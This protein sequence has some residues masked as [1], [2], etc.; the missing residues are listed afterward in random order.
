MDS[1]RKTLQNATAVA[2]LPCSANYY[3]QVLG[4]MIAHIIAPVVVAFLGVWFYVKEESKR[5]TVETESRCDR[6]ITG[7]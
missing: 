3:R 2:L 5:S 1:I 4:A 7:M 6:M